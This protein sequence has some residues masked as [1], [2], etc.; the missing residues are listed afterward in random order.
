M[1]VGYPKPQLPKSQRWQI[2]RKLIHERAILN[3]NLRGTFLARHSVSSKVVKNDDFP[4]LMLTE[5]TQQ[6]R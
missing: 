4:V 3:Q 1:T 5:T 2:Q 6:V